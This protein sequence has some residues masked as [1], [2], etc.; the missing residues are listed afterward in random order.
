MSIW[1]QKWWSPKNLF[2]RSMDNLELSSLARRV[3]MV[4]G[5]MEKSWSPEVGKMCNV[6]RMWD[7]SD[8]CA[9]GGLSVL[10][11]NDFPTGIPS[12]CRYLCVGTWVM[13]ILEKSGGGLG[14]R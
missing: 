10:E 2:V 6:Q 13:R 9:G 11:V 14:A 8:I 3:M 12:S 1:S 4:D 5:E 7:I